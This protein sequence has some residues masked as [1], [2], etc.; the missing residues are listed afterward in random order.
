[1]KRLIMAA[2]AAVLLCGCWNEAKRFGYK[3]ADLAD[4][5]NMFFST[6]PGVTNWVPARVLSVCEEYPVVDEERAIVAAAG[7]V[8]P[9]EPLEKVPDGYVKN[10]EEPWF[11]TWTRK[12]VEAFGRKGVTGFVSHYDEDKKVWE[13][14]E[15]YFSSYFKDEASALAALA[16]TRKTVEERFLPK[17]IYD[18]D[19]CWVAEY[20]R[21]RVMCLV[22][23]KADGTWSCMFDISDKNLIGCG[24]WEP[25]PEQEERLAA[26]RYRKAVAAWKDEKAKA[27]ARNHELIEKARAD[28]GLVPFGEDVSK[29]E[30]DDGRTAYTRGGAYPP[31]EQTPHRDLW[32]ARLKELVAVTGVSFP[33]EPEVQNIPSGYV[34]WASVASN[35]L[36]EVRLD[37]AFPP[38]APAEKADDADAPPPEAAPRIEWREMCLERILPGVEIPP[39]PQPPAR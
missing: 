24:Q 18:F 35:E 28:K 14:G 20:R 38:P 16:D 15:T 12:D 34:V 33:A 4:G 27:I 7:V 2:A 30:R 36:Y 32:D 17:K 21:L 37:M 10:I 29:S 8:W 11:V 19:H 5:D 3:G 25:L 13:T 39:R 31:E 1:M 26:F 9:G 23:Q 6:G 22:G